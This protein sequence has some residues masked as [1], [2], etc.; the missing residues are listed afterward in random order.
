MGGNGNN[1]VSL[2]YNID[3]NDANTGLHR[4]YIDNIDNIRNVN[5]GTTIDVNHHYNDKNFYNRDARDD[6]IANHNYSTY[7]AD[8]TVNGDGSKIGNEI[9]NDDQRLQ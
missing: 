9:T 6:N 7:K 4:H 3:G 2:R 5:Y 1:S 8:K